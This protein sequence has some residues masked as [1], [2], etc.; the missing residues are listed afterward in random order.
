M[1]CGKYHWSDAVI[2]KKKEERRKKKEGLL[3]GIRLV[4]Y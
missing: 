2:N 3:N 1:K 4:S